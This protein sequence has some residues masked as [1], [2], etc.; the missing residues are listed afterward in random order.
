[1]AQAAA[2]ATAAEGATRRDAN[3]SGLDA[4]QWMAL[5]AALGWTTYAQANAEGVR[6]FLAPTG[7]ATASLVDAA[8]VLSDVRLAI[9]TFGPD[10]VAMVRAS[11][12]TRT[13]TETATAGFLSGYTDFMVR[14]GAASKDLY[15]KV[16]RGQV[17]SGT[18][19]DIALSFTALADTVAAT[20]PQPNAL[21]D[22][23]VQNAKAVTFYVLGNTLVTGSSFGLSGFGLGSDPVATDP[24][25]LEYSVQASAAAADA[26]LGFDQAR[27]WNVSPGAWSSAWGSAMYASLKGGPRSAAGAT[28]ALNELWYAGVNALMLRAAAQSAA[29]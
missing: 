8:Q 22:E 9:S 25:R 24:A 1:M 20:P 11:P 29:P 3:P 5:P 10:A 7:T 16:S 13:M 28:I 21:Q 12:S 23:I 18:A 26:W 2:L 4:G 27:G 6:V 15:E 17:G 14:A 19:G